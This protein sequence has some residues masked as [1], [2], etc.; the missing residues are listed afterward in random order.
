MGRDSYRQSRRFPGGALMDLLSR[1]FILQKGHSF[2]VRNAYYS[3]TEIYGRLK[4]W[5]TIMIII[6][7][8]RN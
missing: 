6:S 1:F 4:R 3:S 7:R 5:E 2:V 8:M